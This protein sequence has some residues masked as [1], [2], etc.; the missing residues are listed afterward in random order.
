[1]AAPASLKHFSSEKG[2]ALIAALLLLVLTSA[3]AVALLMTVNTEQNL[4][5]TDLGNNQAYYA[6]EAGMENMMSD[7]YNL[8]S[9]FQSPTVAQL[10]SIQTDVPTAVPN[11][12]Y[13]EYILN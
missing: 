6:A 12:T 4:Q 5:R 9:Q 10:T 13:P 11:A 8:Y 2:V 3:V 1:M 7:L